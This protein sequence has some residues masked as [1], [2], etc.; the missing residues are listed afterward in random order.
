MV[1][2]DIEMKKKFFIFVSIVPGIAGGFIGTNLIG[3]TNIIQS[4]GMFS[5]GP[6]NGAPLFAGLV[7]FPFLSIVASYIVWR[8]LDISLHLNNRNKLP[9]EKAS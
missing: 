7:I 4:L 9:H 6:E 3:E 1:L 5:D 8:L 2:R